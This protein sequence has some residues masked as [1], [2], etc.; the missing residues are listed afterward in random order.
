[1]MKIAILDDYQNL[2]LKSA[3][4][5]TFEGKAD[6]TVFHDTIKDQAALNRRL[7]PFDII[8]AMRERTPL[9]AELLAGLPNLKLIV[10]TG[11]RNDAVDVA[12]A[13]AKGVVVCGTESPSTATPELTFALILGLARNLANENRSMRNGG[14]QVGLG[15]DLAGSTLGIIG[16]GRL[17]AKVAGIAKAFDMNVIAW[18]ENL[19]DERCAEVG[20]T[21]AS[22]AD[23]LAKSDFITIHQRLSDRTRN[24][25]TKD[26]FRQM[27]STAFLINTSRGPI[28]NTDDLLDAVD[29]G[30]IAGA[31]IDVYAEEPLPADHP[32]RGSDRLLLTPHLG[33]VTRGTWDVFYGQTVEAITAWLAGSPIRVIAP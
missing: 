7:A 6:I 25:M 18:S 29:H 4:W 10:T 19:T 27:K 32:L 5:R 2:A 31:G 16:L 24:L 23:L 12:A 33:Y 13:H 11:K 26:D 20:V 28:V 17:G 1:M 21:R 30:I 22:K 8:C 15:H 3:D 9:S 14:W